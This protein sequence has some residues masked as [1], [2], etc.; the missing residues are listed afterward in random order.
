MNDNRMSPPERSRYWARMIAVP[1]G[2][3]AAMVM[4]D[5]PW[6]MAG[7]LVLLAGVLQFLY[8]ES[9]VMT[10][11]TRLQTLSALVLT[12]A[13]AVTS[14]MVSSTAALYL[15]W[16]RFADYRHAYKNS[17]VPELLRSDRGQMYIVLTALLLIG[18]GYAMVR[19]YFY[20]MARGTT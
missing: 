16:R 12:A 2:G 5:S 4:A 3:M 14:P 9:R 10:G 7:Y 8:Y 15:L 6:E 17:S 19:L 20:L 18:T 13:L 11:H 1:A